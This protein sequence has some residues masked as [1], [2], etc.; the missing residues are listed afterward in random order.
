MNNLFVYDLAVQRH[1]DLA[2]AAGRPD[3]LMSEDA[4]S[5][6]SSRRRRGRRT[7]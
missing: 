2:R 4:R 7:R 6:R 1:R 5:S 3:R